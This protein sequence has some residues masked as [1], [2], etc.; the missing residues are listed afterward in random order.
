MTAW[1][2]AP[3]SLAPQGASPGGASGV[4]GGTQGCPTCPA[5]N[6]RQRGRRAARA[7]SATSRSRAKGGVSTTAVAQRRAEGRA[8]PTNRSGVQ[9]ATG[10][11]AGSR[12]GRRRNPKSCPDP[13]RRTKAGAPNGWRDRCRRDTPR[14][15]HATAR[16]DASRGRCRNP[17]AGSE[18][19]AWQGADRPSQL[20][21]M[22]R[23]RHPGLHRPG[24]RGVAR[25]ALE[26]AAR[27]H[28]RQRVPEHAADGGNGQAGDDLHERRRAM[29]QPRGAPHAKG[30]LSTVTAS[31]SRS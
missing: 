10:R 24:W 11:G 4:G 1:Y 5:A 29:A 8:G 17:V 31:A 23:P 2:S 30:R 18:R 3:Q 26:R 22:T 27:L 19:P 20:N 16:E 6:A 15:P 28:N 25:S 9:G 21:W 14:P 7:P 13:G 12:A